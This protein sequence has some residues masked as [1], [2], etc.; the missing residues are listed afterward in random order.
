MLR[1]AAV[2]FRFMLD[3]PQMQVA[4]MNMGTAMHGGMACANLFGYIDGVD[5]E[6]EESTFFFSQREVDLALY[7]CRERICPEG[8]GTWGQYWP[9]SKTSNLCLLSFCISDKYKELLLHS[10]EF[11]PHLVSGLLFDPKTAMC[12]SNPH[13][14]SSAKGAIQLQYAECLQQLSLYEPSRR[15]MIADAQVMGAL[16]ELTVHGWTPEAKLCAHGALLALVEQDQREQRSSR[17]Q[18]GGDGVGDES[19]LQ[20]VMMS[21]EWSSQALV[22]RL[23]SELKHRGYRIWVDIEAMKGSTLDAMSDAV[24]YTTTVK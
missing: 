6:D 5:A 8:E 15:A 19:R 23:V 10:R 11:L 12:L 21:Y 20:H 3:V 7:S 13:F 14:D 16:R 22:K 2:A 24:S 9:C 4:S 17:Q 1:E 18:A